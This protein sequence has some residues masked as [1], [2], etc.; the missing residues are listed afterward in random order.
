MGG[1]ENFAILWVAGPGN[2]PILR[3]GGMMR[4]SQLKVYEGNSAGG[5]SKEA[6]DSAGGWSERKSDSMGG[7][8]EKASVA[9]PLL[10]FLME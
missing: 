7:W 2:F 1:L 9:T 5:W 10:T 4:P 3:E 8:F 6:C